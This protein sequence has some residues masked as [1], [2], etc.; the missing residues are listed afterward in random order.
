MR[1]H[2]THA[3]CCPLCGLRFANRP[4]L[5]LH[6]RDDHAPPP[7]AERRET[8]RTTTRA[9]HRVPAPRAWPIV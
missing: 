8:I 3:L 1:T 5:E 2:T 9:W 4:T 6:A 7:Q